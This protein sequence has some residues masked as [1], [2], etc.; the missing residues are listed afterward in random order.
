MA[1]ASNPIGRPTDY[2]EEVAELICERIA[3][4]EG[5]VKICKS[6][7]MPHRSTV[8]RWLFKYKE[9][10]D[11]YALAREAQADFLF[12]EILDIS[13]GDEKDM[14]LDKDG[15]PTGKVNHENINRSRLRVD[16][17]K[18]VIARLAPKKYGDRVDFDTENNNWTVNGIP[19]K[20]R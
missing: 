6:E 1:K 16:T 11:R 7:D 13:D 17:R 14:L 4:G 2:S 20:T 8:M 5:L 19:V 10:S 18:W 15:N 12:E 9:F 3:G